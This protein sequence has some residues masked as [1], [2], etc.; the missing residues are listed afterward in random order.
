M[1]RRFV[2]RDWTRCEPQ[3]CIKQKEDFVKN[4]KKMQRALPHKFTDIFLPFNLVCITADGY[5]Q[6]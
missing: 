4:K 1:K 5:S 2:R 3:F 6:V